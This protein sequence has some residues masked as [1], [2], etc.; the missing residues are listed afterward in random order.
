MGLCSVQSFPD[1]R[2]PNAEYELIN[3]RNPQPNSKPVF[4]P[5]TTPR[6]VIVITPPP[7]PGDSK[8]FVY[9][10]VAKTWTMLK[11]NDP[12]PAEDALIWNQNNDKWLTMV[13]RV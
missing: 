1:S 8:N 9:D 2:N 6:S 12:P 7:P 13:A 5:I 3:P 4:V 10:P 11:K